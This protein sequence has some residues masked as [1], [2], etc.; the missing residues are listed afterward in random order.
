MLESLGKEPITFGYF[1]RNRQKSIHLGPNE[2]QVSKTVRLFSIAQLCIAFTVFLWHLSQPFVGDLF[3]AKAQ[4]LVFEEVMGAAPALPSE[5]RILLAERNR[6][7]YNSLPESD[8]VLISKGYAMA[9]EQ[10][11]VSF[12]TKLKGSFFHLWERISL[13][14]QAWLLLSIVVPILLLKQVEG[15]RLAV[16]LIPLIS[17][18]YV[19]DN[20]F[21]GVTPEPT[22]QELL[23]P[24]EE[25]LIQNYMSEPLDER[26]LQ[27]HG[28]LKEAW[29][30]YLVDVW[31]S[32]EKGEGVEDG[33]Y[34][35]TLARAKAIV[36]GGLAGK[37]HFVVLKDPMWL[38]VGIVGWNLLFALCTLPIKLS[39]KSKALSF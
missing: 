25:F 26:I 4:L 11:G 13:F 32:K 7:R 9:Q 35:F 8:R 20:Q 12:G 28:Q 5:E 6:L 14:E 27:Q 3:R 1:M 23:F 24:S 31:T 10:K 18:F 17:F 19:I 33:R 37:G 38:V 15:A 2:S 36:N 30:R 16:W 21:Y 39:K 22:E 29:D 34:A